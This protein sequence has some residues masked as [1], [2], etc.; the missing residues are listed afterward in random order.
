MYLVFGFAFLGQFFHSPF[1]DIVQLIL[2]FFHFFVSFTGKPGQGFFI[3]LLI[4]I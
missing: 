4:R 1:Q 2:G 3:L